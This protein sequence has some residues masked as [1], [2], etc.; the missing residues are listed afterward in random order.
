MVQGK[1]MIFGVI[2]PGWD[3]EGGADA[4]EV[5]GHYFYETTGGRV[6]GRP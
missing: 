6:S 1:Y 3:V 2:R 4:E 5:D